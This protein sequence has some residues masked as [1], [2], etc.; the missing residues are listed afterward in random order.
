MSFAERKEIIKKLQGIRK[1]RVITHINSD[2]RTL[3]GMPVLAGLQTK[4]ATE[5][6]PFFYDALLNIGKSKSIDLFLYTS[7]GQTDS[8]WPLVSI[9]RE[10]G[11]KFNVLV[12]YKA[13]SAGTLVC[14]G[15]DTIVLG[16][17]SELSPVD[18]STGNQFNPI[19]EINKLSRRA[20]SVEEVTS[21][22]ALA[23]NPS[24]DNQEGENG[25]DKNLAF[26][27]LAE[28]VHPLAL[29]NVN[30]SYM[31]IRQ[32]AKRLLCLHLKPKELD[33]DKEVERIVNALT[34]DRYAHSDVLNRNEAK[35]LFGEEMVKI[36]SE[37]EEA[38]IWQLHKDYEKSIKMNTQFLITK[39]I[40]NSQ[41][42]DVEL[43]GAY[44][45]TENKSYEFRAVT[46]ITLTTKLPQ[47]VQIALQPGQPMPIIP[48]L[49][50]EWVFELKD[51]GW[52]ENTGGR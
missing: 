42:V 37:E 19:D 10:F 2:R 6:Q 51:I 22:F 26:K 16:K 18:P 17:A 15:A 33:R 3:E 11:E 21:Y 43:I 23:K 48:G 12:P 35:D 34:K 25:I 27:I 20:I 1:S 52:F 40:G 41:N 13:H 29:G 28:S 50:K 9:I 44:I 30:R 32:L 38:L 24:K 7:G 14:L 47:G 45:E 4:M 8:V 5:A 36:P 39:E 31:Q 49:P 46:N